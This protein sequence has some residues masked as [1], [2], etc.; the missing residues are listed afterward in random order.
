M[1]GESSI[2]DLIHEL[3]QRDVRLR[4]DKGELSVD[5]PKGVLLQEDVRR[6]RAHKEQI[7]SFLRDMA[8]H[9]EP[10]ALKPW[11]R[12]DHIPL[13]F[14]QQ[15]LWIVDQ[16]SGQR[17]TARSMRYHLPQALRLRGPLDPDILQRV[18]DTLIV[19]HE[20][21]RTRFATVDG[22]PVQS[23]AAPAPF[24][25]QR[26]DLRAHAAGD[27]E[28]ELYRVLQREMEEPFDLG[29]GPLI[30]GS[31][32][33]MGDDD[34]ALFIAMHHIAS[35]GWSLQILWRET[36]ALYD[37]YRVGEANP[38]PPVEIQYA[39]Y[40]QWERSWLQG[41]VLEGHLDYWK[42]QLSGAAGLDLPRD[43]VLPPVPTF[44]G[45]THTFALP[46]DVTAGLRALSSSSACSLFMTL[47]AV[48]HVMLSRLSGQ[49]DFPVVT[50][51]AGRSH[52]GTEALVGLCVNSLVLRVSTEAGISFRRL[53]AKTRRVVLDAYRHQDLP[54][55][56]LIAWIRSDRDAALGG[57]SFTM[58]TIARG[59]LQP[60]GLQ[61]EPVLLPWTT[62]KSE[63]TLSVHE[64][65]DELY[66]VFE[67]A[68]D[69][70]DAHTVASFERRFVRAAQ[71]IV[72]NPDIA[73][74]AIDV[75]LEG[76][77]PA[78][79]YRYSARYL[80]DC[81]YWR[82]TRG[83]TE[84]VSLSVGATGQPEAGLLRAGVE[85]DA[86]AVRAL[87]RASATYKIAP[88]QLLLAAIALYLH[89]SSTAEPLCFGLATPD[90]DV[91][92]VVLDVDGA[93][94]LREFAQTVSDGCAAA[95]QHRGCG[96]ERIRQ[97][98]GVDEEWRCRT[99]VSLA[100]DDSGGVQAGS[101]GMAAARID[102]LRIL[103]SA[104]K[105]IR[106]T[107]QGDQRLFEAW[108]LEAHLAAL[109]MLL[110]QMTA[111]KSVRTTVRSTPL[112]SAGP[113]AAMVA[114]SV[115]KRTR[116]P[117][118]A[119]IH[120][121]FEAQAKRQ[122]EALAVLHGAQE[123]RYAELNARANRLAHHLRAHDVGPGTLVVVCL[124][125]SPDLIV[126]LLA[127]LKSG[128]AYVPVDPATAAERLQYIIA[129][130]QAAAVVTQ[131]QLA[132]LL[133]DTRANIIT[134]DADAAAIAQRSASNL[135]RAR[136]QPEPAP[137]YVIYTSGSTGEPKGVL[138]GHG[139]L[140][141]HA[142][143]MQREFAL[144]ADDRALQFASISF[145]ASAE[146]IYPTLLAG[147]AIVLRPTAV[148]GAQELLQSIVAQ[149]VTVLNL[150]TAYWHVFVEALA[151][152]RVDTGRLRLIIV[153]GERVSLDS[154]LRWRTVA[155]E[156][157]EWVNTYGPTEATI[158]S[159]LYRAPKDCSGLTGVPIGRP[160][161]NV[162][163]YL[164]DRDGQPV[165]TGVVGELCIG[166]AGVAAGYWH[167]DALTAERFVADPFAKIG[168]A[169]MYR[170]GDLARWL[171]DGN[172]AYVGRNDD[173]LKLRGFRIEPGE[174]ET[175]LRA[176][177]HVREATVLLREDVP[178][179]RRL[180][181]Y[182][183]SAAAPATLVADLRERLQKVLPEYM[184]PSAFVVLD[185]LPMTLNGKL[186]RRALPA[187]DAVG[188]DAPAHEEP[189]GAVEQSLAQIWRDV[190]H[191]ERV[192]RHANFFDL[193][194]SSISAIQV[195]GRANQAGL[196]LNLNAIFEE[197]SIANLASFIERNGGTAAAAAAKRPGV[198]LQAPER[199]SITGPVP[200]TPIQIGV[201][202]Q[203]ALAVRYMT[204]SRVLSCQRVLAADVLDTA[205][206]KLIIY[207]DALRL[208][209]QQD[210]AGE[211]S[212][213]IA[214]AAHVAG[215]T[216]L[217][218][219]AAASKEGI[220]QLLNA[221]LERTAG[222]I[223]PSTGSL[224]QATLV[225]VGQ[226]ASEGQALL[227]AAHHFAIDPVSWEILVQDLQT[228]Y[229]QLESGMPA[230][231]PVKGASFK[232]WSEALQAYAN[233]PEA[234]AEFDYWRHSGWQCRP[235]LPVERDDT[236]EDE[237]LCV[238]V[239]L[240][241]AQTR[242]LLTEVPRVHGAPVNEVLL[243][244]LTR[245]L[246]GWCG[247]TQF[248][249][250][251]YHHGRVGAFGN[252]D[253]SRTVGW[254]TAPVPLLLDVAPETAMGATLSHVKGSLRAIPNEGVGYGILRHLR[255]DG[256]SLPVA[257]IDVLLNHQG[258]VAGEAPGGR[259]TAHFDEREYAQLLPK[260]KLP[261]KLAV[262]SNIADG[263]LRANFVS[264]RYS[265]PTLQLIAD[266]FEAALR[267]LCDPLQT[268]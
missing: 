148:P 132:G 178:G 105:K 266:A 44:R 199:G 51:V 22:V 228:I 121:R 95:V 107:V 259:F 49:R 191:L 149:Q 177:P 127:V 10:P 16:L 101:A 235:E 261:W 124:E 1:S 249:L 8:E 27:R 116:M 29:A 215:Y 55:E 140:V 169:R 117:R 30:R 207:H 253:L 198:A 232:A 47:F 88:P 237:A 131:S 252:L 104:S 71:Q 234:A 202:G 183:G 126:A 160:I 217:E 73:L 263:C 13:S 9:V 54:F 161:D 52:P 90:G 18:L 153:G 93:M 163:T 165:P 146:E 89:K 187:P 248:S 28:A 243:A 64:A 87:R 103:I 172:I 84:P 128:A 194:G 144:T 12:S 102:E 14:A 110:A 39:D 158:T 23:I 246:H 224:L 250:G 72:A 133:P 106:I 4:M 69:S 109:R 66:G 74:D 236:G 40:A 114:N 212:Q 267:E 2:D 168:A 185:A 112:L 111:P 61:V 162:G 197:Q 258:T 254:F 63:L 265:R 58:N 83:D 190:L 60:E 137:A 113:R 67:Y 210:D 268:H 48:F 231:L 170:S 96:S 77:S 214:P 152:S 180:V 260:F 242:A 157:I 62:A 264:C 213:T 26:L 209:I 189:Q 204:A 70:F 142:S 241:A 76:E 244:A 186:D 68:C 150:P 108:E 227:L 115:G 175:Q 94:E 193:G 33:C 57:V 135:R 65:P 11:P 247:Q 226:D 118:G 78:A 239:G 80:D 32:L 85:L 203:G 188:S 99:V 53:L 24:P 97:L 125:R 120:E 36:C 179:D 182:V 196:K 159:T 20:V 151:G 19:R 257:E 3:R 98:R 256:D 43:H 41:S 223:D 21:L 82:A 255:A 205:L 42:R 164:L 143:W 233:A 130:T 171:P 218:C 229:E 211:W 91:L 166:G 92:P 200:F 208:C 206:R 141:N 139:N 221:A 201:L 25:L 136:A 59:Q 6:L 46:Q 156:A 34:H 174:I 56:Q 17:G 251:M 15:R 79:Q 35:D 45:A 184:V 240:D 100:E 219:E 122:P 31:L 173:Q 238:T 222:R 138:V 119:L 145:D 50:P 225:S 230:R 5:A 245:A 86:A 181:A 167:R 262:L 38:L 123:I 154:L 147:A 129:D 134:L 220:A 195:I 7:L 216:V 37:G 176:C 81:A 155:G 75:S 192:D